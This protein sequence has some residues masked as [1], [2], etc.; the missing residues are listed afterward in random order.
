M[1]NTT[2]PEPPLY[3]DEKATVV[4][5]LEFLRATLRWKCEG[6]TPEQLGLRAV[7]PSEMSLHGLIRHLTEV[8]LS[9]F[10]ECFTDEEMVY[11][12]TA[13]RPNGDWADLDPASY[14]AD[15]ERYDAAVARVRSIVDGLEPD[16]VG[17]WRGEPITLRWVLTHMV[18]EYGRHCGHADLLRERIDGRTGE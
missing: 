4:G 9:W 7:E 1:E 13:D 12:Y 10:V 16:A 6:L 18:E 17:K 3:A 15:L 2:R 5:F 8:E 11:P 14:A